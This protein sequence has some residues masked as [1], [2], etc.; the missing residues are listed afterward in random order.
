MTTLELLVQGLD[1]GHRELNIALG[2]LPDED[3]WRRP[4]PNLLSVGEIVGHVAYWEANRTIGDGQVQSPL[5]DEA[6]QYYTTQQS[7]PFT[8]EMGTKELSAELARIHAIG[9]ASLIALNPNLDD[10]FP[11]QFQATWG[12]CLQ[13]M[14][15]HVAY[16]TGQIYSVRHMFGHATEDN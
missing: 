16:H 15:F 13:Y 7:Q 9:K 3:L 4:H 2:G 10:P 11:G 5:L 1:E 14:V 8:L 6:F 12:D